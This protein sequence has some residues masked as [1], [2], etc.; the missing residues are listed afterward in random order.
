MSKNR[1][2][3]SA[4]L[5]LSLAWLGCGK[6]DELAPRTAFTPPG[7][8][9]ELKMKWPKG[10]RIVEEM[11]IKEN[12]EISI[13][14]RSIP[15]RQDISI[16]QQLGLRVLNESPGGEQKLELEFHNARVEVP[17]G[18]KTLSNYDSTK[19]S[20]ADDVNPVAGMFR[21]IIG[22]KVQFFLNASNDVERIEGADEL[23]QKL[24]SAGQGNHLEHF[25]NYYSEGFLRQMMIATRSLPTKPVQPGDQWPV[26]V[27]FATRTGGTLCVDDN[28][29]FQGWEKHAGRNCARLEF[30]GT[31]SNK[32]E[33]S[34]GSARMSVDIA[35]GRSSGV[36]WFAPDLGLMIETAL[37]HDLS[38]AITM[39]VN[40]EGSAEAAPRV[41]KIT[42]QMNQVIN[43]KLISVK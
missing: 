8:P 4:T 27:E 35:D 37:K 17:P 33:A 23:A 30:K 31:I 42:E 14:G 1:L 41:R 15:I 10:G 28:F 3:I 34:A 19:K 22:S 2:T 6:S 11:D 40:P 32:P 13:P 21:K 39:P 36:S 16:T 20:P 18:S 26:H 9:I 12:S 7:G 25:K 29:T 43:V 38:L 5:A 24:E